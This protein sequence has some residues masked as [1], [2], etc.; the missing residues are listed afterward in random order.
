[1]VYENRM[2][3]ANR[4]GYEF[5]WANISS[6]DHG[7]H[8]VWNKIPILKEAFARF[9]QA[10]WLYWLDIDII[11]MTPSIN[12][13]DHVLTQA[14]LN[15]NGAFGKELGRVGGGSSGYTTPTT[16]DE[17]KVNFIISSD[18]WGMN[19]GTFLM[20]RSD[21]TDWLLDMWD[22]PLYIKADW[23]MKE[24]QAWT[25][26]FTNHEIIRNHT[27]HIAQKGL[28]SYPSYN[29]LGEHWSEGDLLVHFAGC[30]GSPKCAKNWD[31][32]WVQREDYIVPDFVKDELASER[33]KIENI[34]MG[35]YP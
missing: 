3:W 22:D 10:K 16:V 31:D 24:N 13:H 21:W 27:A 9:P 19:A 33:A 12:L 32:M 7:E 30:G 20:R 11:I 14:G 23:V 28:N 2:S 17:S 18:H 34:Q 35:V 4:W 25:H 26:M 15:K 8:V 29:F 6:Y 1:M 5:M